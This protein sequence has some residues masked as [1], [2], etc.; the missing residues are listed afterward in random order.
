MKTLLASTDAKNNSGMADAYGLLENSMFSALETYANVHRGSGPA[1][2][3][4]TLLYEKARNVVLNYLGL[5]RKRYQ[6]V[7]CSPLRATK[8]VSKLEPGNYHRIGSADIGLNLGVTALAVK[9]RALPKGIPSVTG[10]GTTRLYGSDWVMWAK[11]PARYEAGTPA[12]INCIALAKALMII[13]QSGK[14]IFLK[15]DT[16]ALKVD[17]I[18]YKDMWQHLSGM[19][20]LKALREDWI[21]QKLQVPT[22]KGLSHYIN[23][24]NSA[25]T[26]AFEPVWQTY[27]KAYRQPLEVQK[28]LVDEVKA[29]V[30]QTFGAPQE[31]YE[32]YFTSNTTEAINLVAD[33]MNM[34]ALPP[35]GT[36]NDRLIVG[37]VLEHSSNDL[38]W[39]NVSG[40]T[41]IR[42]PVDKDG[43]YDLEA[44]E[45]LLRD[46]N[47]SGLHGN[48]R[49]GLVAL[50]G[51]SN[52][53]GTCNDLAATGKLIRRFGAKFLVDAA[54]LAAHR[55]IDMASLNIDYLAFS[56]HKM[57]A[58][59]GTGVLIA[60]KNLL[61]FKLQERRRI[62][63]S[64][65]ENI[66][67][68]AALGK[69]LFLLNQIGFDTIE[70]EEQKLLRKAISGLAGIPGVTIHGYTGRTEN[71][72]K[73]HTAV[74]PFEIKN[75]LNS[76]L[77]KRLAGQGGIGTRFGCHC[78][79]L[80]L[81]SLLDFSPA[82]DQI[83]RYV[84]KIVPILNLQGVLRVSFGLQ[85][86][87][88]D[89]DV[90]LQSLQQK[91]GL[92]RKKFNDYL[93]HRIA[94][95]FD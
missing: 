31:Q 13:Q 94:A 76:S 82:Q 44:L 19:D 69:A 89:V 30:S 60:R 27:R 39:R 46:Y 15:D 67:G 5:N 84:L 22:T 37:S 93:N 88:N 28:A 26:S 95:V 33:S 57:Y 7:F 66:G 38:P 1:S 50:S 83:Q 8:L 55:S 14:N 71:E 53:T 59:F 25:S 52:I 12:I 92:S 20:L 45:K 43:F 47:E 74:I 85:N 58:P 87:E 49:I 42:L 62:Q 32:V 86:T 24:D 79:H 17:E 4:T 21:G 56:G 10:G 68:I 34:G 40:H 70:A 51:A 16:K 54:Q 80:L 78:A 61:N 73:H 9:Q 48:K 41:L 65:N 81:K 6:V 72:T 91:G 29:I 77:A 3:V 35:L 2:A 75:N 18:L 23:L 36:R 90:M 11:A 64:G 63:A